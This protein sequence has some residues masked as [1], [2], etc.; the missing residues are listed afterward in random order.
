MLVGLA[1]HLNM[2]HIVFYISNIRK[3]NREQ[4]SG[5]LFEFSLLKVR[6]WEIE[7]RASWKK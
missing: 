3:K 7:N 1:F 5:A 6:K 2:F 4:N